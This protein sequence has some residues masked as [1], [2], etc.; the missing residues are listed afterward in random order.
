MIRSSIVRTKESAMTLLRVPL[1]VLGFGAA[2]LLV[3]SNVDIRAHA[4]AS[5]SRG[6]MA[7]N[8]DHRGGTAEPGAGRDP[9]LGSASGGP[10]VGHDGRHRHRSHDGNIWAYERCGAGNGRRRSRRL[11]QHAARSGLQVRSEDRRRAR[12][13]RQ[14]RDGD[15]ARHRRGQAGQRVDRRF[16]GQQG[17]HQGASGP[18]V[19]PEGREA[20]EP[21]ASRASPATPTASSTSRTTW[22]SAPTAASTW[23]TDTTRRA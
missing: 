22:W 20:A 23:P 17:G 3:N 15:A 5:N 16:R 9:E 13:F 7:G 12:E 11:R 1:C 19:Q 4:Q 6:A 21:R 10:Q 2:V 14:G 18:Q 8:R